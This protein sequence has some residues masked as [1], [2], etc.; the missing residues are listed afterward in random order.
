MQ[1][2]NRWIVK[3]DPSVIQYMR[4]TPQQVHDDYFHTIEGI[5]DL[6]ENFSKLS[7]ASCSAGFIVPVQGQNAALRCA[8]LGNTREIHIFGIKL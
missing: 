2:A 6:A 4:G 3:I 5:L 1:N 7:I 8:V